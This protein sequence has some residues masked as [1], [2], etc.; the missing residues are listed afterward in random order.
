MDREPELSKTRLLEAGR[1]LAERE[2]LQ[3]LRLRAVARKAGVNVG[4]FPYHFGSKRRFVRRMLQDIYDEFFGRLSLESSAGGDALARLR[5]ALIVFGLFV[6][7]ER[8]VLTFLFAE[9][10][11]GDREV[12][13]Y[14]EANA[15]RHARVI[16]GLV[17]QGQKARRLKDLPLP[18]AVAFALGGMGAPNI[19]IT[20]VE[21][22]GSARARRRV[23]EWSEEFLSDRAVERRADLVLA[24]LRR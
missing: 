13:S 11:R 10:A 24:A 21:R 3:A 16:A 1:R 5:R 15:P 12:F 9:A 18:V 17:A 8:R 19:L 7:E 22:G 14:L 6:R 2:G 4:L 23:R 20:A